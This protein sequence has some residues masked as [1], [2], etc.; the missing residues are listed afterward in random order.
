MSIKKKICLVGFMLMILCGIWV[1]TSTEAQAAPKY[2]KLYGDVLENGGID[3]GAGEIL[4]FDYFSLLDINRDGIKELIAV[5][6]YDRRANIYTIKKGKVKELESV[7]CSI[8]SSY[9]KGK[10][11]PYVEYNKAAKGLIL[12]THGGTGMLGNIL[13]KLKGGKLKSVLYLD[14]SHDWSNGVE[15][16]A[17]YSV[18][19]KLVSK[20]TYMKYYNKYFKEG[21]SRK[22][23]LKNNTAKNRNKLK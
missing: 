21:K 20:K 7:V 18:E 22:V 17:M 19:D 16:K 8:R 11:K 9:T 13:Y 15:I 1:G 4:P 14:E 2:K 23:F 10:Y 12:H 3:W 6:A 5:G